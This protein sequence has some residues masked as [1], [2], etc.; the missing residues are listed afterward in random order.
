MSVYVDQAEN[1]LG[2]MKMA[3]MVADT[4]DELHAMADQVGLKRKWFQDNPDH[5]HYDLCQSKKR[6]AISLGAI[7]INSRQLVALVR[8]WR[9]E[10]VSG[11]TLTPADGAT[12][13]LHT[14]CGPDKDGIHFTCGCE[15]TPRR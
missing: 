13:G 5:P 14:F 4:L 1:N 12:C 8:K 9:S 10:K 6:L 11:L 15:I 2:R 7:E 3:H